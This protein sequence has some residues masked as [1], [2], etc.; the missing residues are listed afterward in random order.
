MSGVDKSFMTSWRLVYH[1]SDVNHFS[2]KR[3][4]L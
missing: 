4:Q 2:S 3:Q 1:I